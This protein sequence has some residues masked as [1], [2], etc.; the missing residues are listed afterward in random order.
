ML[1][2]ISLDFSITAAKQTIPGGGKTMLR[3]ISK[4]QV[5]STLCRRFHTAVSKYYNDAMLL[6]EIP[7][8]SPQ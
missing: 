3:Q 5:F 6:A 2:R 8:E 4:P 7:S 1:R